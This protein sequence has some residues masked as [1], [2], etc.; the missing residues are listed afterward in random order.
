MLGGIKKSKNSIW[1][2]FTGSFLAL[3]C[4]GSPLILAFLTEI[5]L[6]FLINDFILFP[7]LFLSFGFT[8]YSLNYNKRRHLNVIPLYSAIVSIILLFMGI[9]FIP[10]LWLCVIGLFV[11]TVCDFILIMKYKNCEVE[12]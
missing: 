4:A 6:G 2:A 12:N 8:I 5:G 9:F 3:C 1:T 7:I 10:I 11:S